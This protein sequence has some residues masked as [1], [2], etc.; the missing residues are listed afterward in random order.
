[1]KLAHVYSPHISL[2][3]CKLP[4]C[5]RDACRCSTLCM[6]CHLTAHLQ[7]NGQIHGKAL[8]GS[9]FEALHVG[10]RGARGLRARKRA[11][12]VMS[13]VLKGVRSTNS[14]FTNPTSIIILLYS[15]GSTV[16]AT[17]SAQLC[18]CS[19]TVRPAS[20]IS[21]TISTRMKQAPGFRSL[22]AFKNA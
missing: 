13:D 9:Q 8:G 2:I 14:T 12:T 6:V 21:R 22:N 3:G 11:P 16:P 5:H 15:H 20:P 1:L 4:R 17:Q 7:H 10:A 18:P 19:S